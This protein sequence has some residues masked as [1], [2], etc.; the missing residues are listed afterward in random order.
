MARNLAEL[1]RCCLES[2]RSSHIVGAGIGTR[3]IGETRVEPRLTLLVDGPVCKD[4]LLPDVKRAAARGE[5]PDFDVLEV[6]QVRALG[7]IG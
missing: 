1:A 6:G 3:K 5:E 7:R 4:E 2:A